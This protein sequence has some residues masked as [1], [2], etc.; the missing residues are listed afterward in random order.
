MTKSARWRMPAEWEPQSGVQLIWPHADT[1]WASIL[2]EIQS[3][4]IE[5]GKAIA[6]RE[7]LL[8]I[9]PKDGENCSASMGGV[10]SSAQTRTMH[11]I[12]RFL[13]RVLSQEIMLT[14]TNLC[15]KAVP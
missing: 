4:Y 1:D 10:R 2:R 11:L 12:G 14:R 15:S 5:M 3:T 8:L 6:E 13:M 9:T 7:R